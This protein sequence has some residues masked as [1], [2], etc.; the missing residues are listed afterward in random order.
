M[1]TTDDHTAGGSE[2]TTSNKKECT[3]CEQKNIDNITEG[4]NCSV[5]ILDNDVSMCACC[6]KEGNSEDMNACNKCKMVQY[7][8]AACKKKHRTKHKKACER[9]VAELHEDALF[10][11]VEPEECPICFLSLP[12]ADKQSF[13]LCCG[14][15]MC[16]GCLYAMYISSGKD[17]CAFCRTP[18]YI[19]DEEIIERMKKLM[20][21]GN[22]E[23]FN[24][25][26][27]MYDDGTYGL[28][29]DVQRANVLYLKSGELGCASGYYNLGNSYNIGTGV[30]LDKKKAIYYWELA[31]IKGFVE[32]R[33]NLGCREALDGNVEQAIKHW[34]IAARA[35]DETSLYNVKAGF[36]KGI[37]TKDE[38]ASTLR[39][40]HERQKEM[41]SEERDMASLLRIL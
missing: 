7:C 29:Q 28:P 3:S 4:I 22:G 19:S 12:V 10:K 41:K 21:K 17:L 25:L 14:K 15:R 35:G 13:K 26:A 23:A 5:A 34:L 1:S 9:R 40:Y 30:E 38:Y 39:A 20:D 27:M 32:A 18:E 36:T 16:N 2:E 11:D 8:N 33:Y 6:G 24:N 37:V 31:A